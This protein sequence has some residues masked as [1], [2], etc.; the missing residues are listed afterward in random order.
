MSTVGRHIRD[1]SGMGMASGS[2]TLVDLIIFT[3]LVRTTHSP[4]VLATSLAALAGAMVHFTACKTLVFGR[5]DRSLI[6]SA[7]RYVLVSGM[8][9]IAHTVT[10]TVL[11]RYFAPELA[12]TVSKASVFLVWIYPGSRYFVF[13]PVA[14][15][16]RRAGPVAYSLTGSPSNRRVR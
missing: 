11:A 7:W 3:T 12:W 14:S 8:A 4:L 6:D 13:S 15:R 2:A 9:L 16:A 5:F 10:T 1:I